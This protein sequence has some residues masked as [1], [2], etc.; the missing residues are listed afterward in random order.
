MIVPAACNATRT[1]G[2]MDF[3]YLSLNAYHDPKENA[4]IG[5]RPKK[6]TNTT[7]LKNIIASNQTGWFQLTYPEIYIP[8]DAKGVH[9]DFYVKIY[10]GKI[11]HLMVAFRGT[12]TQQ[13]KFEDFITWNKSVLQGAD[14]PLPD[15]GYWQAAMHYLVRVRSVIID[16]DH[17]GLL[18]SRC[19][20]SFTG[21][22]LGGALANLAIASG[23]IHYPA[24]SSLTQDLRL[25][26]KAISFNAPGIGA[27]PDVAK[28]FPYLQGQV[29]SM[30]ATGDLVSAIGTPFGYVINNDVPEGRHA[31][32]ESLKAFRIAEDINQHDKGIV[33]VACKSLSLCSMAKHDIDAVATTLQ[34]PAVRKGYYD[35][36]ILSHFMKMIMAQPSA[37]TMTFMQ[38]TGWACKH[39]DLNH[40]ESAAPLY[41][42]AA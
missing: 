8:E 26:P 38:L 31:A 29:V 12:V 19:D 15:L 1:L 37:L 20:Y 4:L 27:M 3:A 11:Q 40:D 23:Y 21:H 9:A 41:S 5:R 22:S 7:L 6:V 33:D 32:E 34:I 25:M 2:L 24:R 16:L 39:G 28:N 35:Q 36:H 30:R 17:A 18:S 42:L 14:T 13:D 10:H